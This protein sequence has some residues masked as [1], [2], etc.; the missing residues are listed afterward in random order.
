MT[1]KPAN[2]FHMKGRGRIAPGYVGDL[3][4]FDPDLIHTDATYERPDVPP[5]RNSFGVEAGKDAGELRL[6][7]G[8]DRPEGT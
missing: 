5:S 2:R 3:T 7:D 8:V 4:I 1:G 6:G